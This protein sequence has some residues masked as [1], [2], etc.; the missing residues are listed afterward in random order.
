MG[1][2]SR[3]KGKRGERE[4]AAELTALGLPA[5]RGQQYS[6]ASGDADVVGLPGVHIECKRV[7]S[8]RLADALDQAERD[9]RPGELPVVMHRRNGRL[10]VAVMRYD[11]FARMSSPWPPPWIAYTLRS[12]GKLA[13]YDE[14]E[15]ASLALRPGL[16]PALDFVRAGESGAELHVTAMWLRDWAKAYRKW[17]GME[18]ERV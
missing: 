18:G 3:D 15:G 17:Q 7:E 12:G 1:K 13:L 9:A 14:M 4:L 10:W 5:R 16:V 11:E 8:L 2:A 6:G